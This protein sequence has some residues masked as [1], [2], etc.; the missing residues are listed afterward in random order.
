MI[1]M[2]QTCSKLSQI[3]SPDLIVVSRNYK[4]TWAAAILTSLQ[5]VVRT[6]TEP[7]ALG[8]VQIP[9]TTPGAANN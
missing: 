8:A 4:R 2:Y 7:A 1:T 9:K 6:A 3:L 5:V